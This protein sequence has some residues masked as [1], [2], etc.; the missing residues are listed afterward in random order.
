M[1]LRFEVSGSVFRVRLMGFVVWGF[2][3]RFSG[4]GFWGFKLGVVGFGVR[5]T[6]LGFMVKGLGIK[7]GIRCTPKLEKSALQSLH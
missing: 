5:V 6:V 1:V 2:G 3:C 7:G 4:L